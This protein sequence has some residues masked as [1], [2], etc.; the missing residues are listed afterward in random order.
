MIF[1]SMRE[2]CVVCVMI[3]K[4][5][6]RHFLRWIEKMIYIRTGNNAKKMRENT[7]LILFKRKQ[8]GWS[9]VSEWFE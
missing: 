6:T 8:Y 4:S 9:Q 3:L 7:H 2:K 1:E 5:Y